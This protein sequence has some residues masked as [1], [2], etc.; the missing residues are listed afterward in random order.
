MLINKFVGNL[1]L[2]KVFISG[3]V[4]FKMAYFHFQISRGAILNNCDVFR[5]FYCSDTK[6][7]CLITIGQP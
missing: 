1:S 5:L 7:F 4:N 3:K 2:K 6:S